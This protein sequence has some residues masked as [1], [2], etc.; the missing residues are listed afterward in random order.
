MTS[1]KLCDR[2]LDTFKRIGLRRW[3]D[4]IIQPSKIRE[5]IVTLTN[6]IRSIEKL[7]GEV[8][9]Y[10]DAREYEKAQCAI[11]DIESKCL[12]LRRHIKQLQWIAPR[13]PGS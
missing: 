11:D 1:E 12:K 13:V 3:T 8:V 7:S 2:V 5:Y 4:G 10:A 9:R 6:H